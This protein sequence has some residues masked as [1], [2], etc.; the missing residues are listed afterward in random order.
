VA[1][2][3]ERFAA[4]PGTAIA[5]MRAILG[6]DVR[7]V[8]PLVGVPALVL[9]SRNGTFVRPSTVAISP[10]ICPTRACW[11]GTVPTTGRSPSPTCSERSKSS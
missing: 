4:T 11:S 1:R 9:A 10:S 5:K 7:K 2:T 8:L 3:G 6:L